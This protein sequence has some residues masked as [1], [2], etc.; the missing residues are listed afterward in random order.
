MKNSL[1]NRFL[2]LFVVVASTVG[3]ANGQTPG[4]GESM[5]AAMKEGVVFMPNS[6][7]ELILIPTDGFFSKLSNTKNG[8]IIKVNG[9]IL[10]S[11]SPENNAGE[12]PLT[13]VKREDIYQWKQ[14]FMKKYPNPSSDNLNVNT[15]NDLALALV[16]GMSQQV[17]LP[18]SSGVLCKLSK[19]GRDKALFTSK[20]GVNLNK[21]IGGSTTFIS[22][23]Q[24]HQLG[25]FPIAW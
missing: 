5:P 12:F 21:T 14:Q 7:S 20:G 15:D 18:I 11:D 19:I 4:K 3:V 23:S 13:C 2:S 17:K 10:T 1:I 9:I 24:N 25:L 8:G 16:I 6:D 22:S